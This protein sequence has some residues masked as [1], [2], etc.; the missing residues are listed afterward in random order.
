[1]HSP[2]AKP[3][4]PILN[5]KTF[6]PASFVQAAPGDLTDAHGRVLRDLRI[7]I[8]DRCNFRCTYCMPR[9]VFDENHPFLARSQL[10]SFEE[11]TRLARLFVARGVRKIRLTGGEPLLRKN[12][13]MLVAMLKALGPIDVTLTTNGVLLPRF[14]DDLKQAGLSRLTVSL[15]ALDNG[16]F[17][18]F[19]DTSHT[20]DDVLRGIKAAEKASFESLK[21]NMVVK[22]GANEDQILPL[23][24]YFRG[25]SHILRFI[26][27]MDV[28]T[29]NGWKLDDVVTAVEILNKIHDRYPIEPIRPNYPGEVA[30]R[31]RFLDGKGEIGVISSVTRAF[32]GSCCRLRLST[33]GQLYTCLFADQSK[34][35]LR[36]LLRQGAEDVQLDAAIASVWQNRDDRYSERRTENTAI[37]QRAKRIEMSYIGG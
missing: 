35:D 34:A 24:E 16:V 37:P 17:Q 32:C 25:T 13:S 15:D 12:A 33:E 7:S 3:F 20:V 2:A 27:F 30:K 36:T 28:G 26:E 9:E 6:E 19:C 10:L 21:I 22:R 23:V 1:M 29:S 14:A 8:I 11:I 4:I 31:W 18:R 5:A